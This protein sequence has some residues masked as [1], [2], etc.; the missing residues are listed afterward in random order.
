MKHNKRRNVL[1]VYEFLVRTI[2]HSLVEGDKKKSS[3]ALKIL[4]KHF[5]P[6]T[7]LYREF[8][9]INAL[10][11]TT[12]SSEH[13]AASIIKE[14]RVAAGEIDAKELDR[15][16]SLLIK[17]VN[18]SLNDNDF[19]DQHVKEYR[20]YATLQSL[21]NE[22]RS[23]NKD[24]A[25]LASYEDQLMTLLTTQKEIIEEK[26]LSEESS[27]TSRLLMKIMSRKLNE[28]YQNI[29]SEQQ[30]SLVKAYAM[31]STSAN[32]EIVVGKLEELIP[33][34]EDAI[35]SKETSDFLRMKLVETKKTLAE[36]TIE[37]A[38]DAIV[39]RFMLYS[40]LKN[41][42]EEKD[43]GDNNV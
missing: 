34:L 26:M 43:L 33:L 40:K 5:K 20:T 17:N 27:G 15:E 6:G 1:L 4:K 32:P 16:K 36:E 10:A 31:S 12:V 7:N 41:E 37:E 30:R 39:T 25:K 42:L 18:H 22:W 35:L 21:V 23:T 2:S 28:K 13:V 14:A 8:R 29:L 3:M 19:Y 24:I 11:K 38:D 9:L